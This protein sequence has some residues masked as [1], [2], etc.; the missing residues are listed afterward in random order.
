MSQ[1]DVE[2]S[3]RLQS[4]IKPP[5]LVKW[6]SKLSVEYVL[7]ASFPGLPHFCSSVGV[8]YNT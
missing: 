7:V 2:K 8:Q 1:A 5:T 6:L 3:K 4:L